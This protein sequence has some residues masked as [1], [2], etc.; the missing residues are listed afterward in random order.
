MQLLI[1]NANTSE[2]MTEALG[3]RAR[4]VARPGTVVS[5]TRPAWGPESVESWYDAHISAAG[6]LDRLATW[7]GP[8]DGVVMAGFGD[9]GREA[10]R[11][12]VS[13]PVVDI[14]EAA[15]MMALLVG[16]RYA[17]VTTLRRAQPMIEASLTAA[18]L[19]SRCATV[20]SLDISVG[21]VAADPELLVRRFRDEVAVALTAGADVVCL[22]SAALAPLT[23]LLAA[24]VEA[25]VVDGVA[26]AVAL[27]EA[28]HQLGLRTS[29]I[30]AWAPPLDKPRPGW[31]V[32]T[33]ATT[34]R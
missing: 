4:A 26:A 21:A 13:V 27:C 22:G 23:D 7:D 28:C 8:L 29:P 2:P 19:A 6:M 33:A 15:V 12:A 16:H 17:I 30:G 9:V 31:P 20:R 25:P 3:A 32:S 18:G 5:A 24:S 11:E 14:T 1:L 34:D 10:L